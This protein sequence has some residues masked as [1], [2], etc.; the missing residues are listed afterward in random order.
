MSPVIA[1][2]IQPTNRLFEQIIAK[3][4]FD[5]LDRVY[6]KDARILPPGAPTIS[7][8]ENI[9]SF[10]RSAVDSLGVSAGK[11]ETVE[12]EATGDT[13]FEI[14]RGRLDFVSG[15]ASLEV[16]FVVVWKREDGAWKWD[17]DIWNTL[18]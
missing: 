14:G 5:A 9:K 3:R 18:S 17:V 13:G 15:A 8:R 2:D 11:L 12:F 6:T 7:G 1:Q 10:W 4:D 16:K